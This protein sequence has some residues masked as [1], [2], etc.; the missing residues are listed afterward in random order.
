MLMSH[1]RIP[2]RG[3][4]AALLICEACGTVAELDAPESF[5]ALAAALK[6]KASRLPARLLKCRDIA[7]I[8]LQVSACRAIARSYH[9]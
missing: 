9:G 1:A 6:R 2:M 5:A 7:A 8:A 4:P 3:K